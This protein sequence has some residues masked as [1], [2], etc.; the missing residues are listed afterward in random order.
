MVL[1]E[2]LY[3]NTFLEGFQEVTILMW[4]FLVE[5]YCGD[6]KQVSSSFFFIGVTA[7]GRV[8]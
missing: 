7:C 6:L 1:I 5:I 4:A 8:R 2:L 3:I